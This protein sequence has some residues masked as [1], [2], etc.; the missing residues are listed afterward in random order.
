MAK[1]LGFE[2]T[3]AKKKDLE[4]FAPPEN[5]DGA[6]PIA[7][8]GAF[9]QYVDM[10]GSIKSEIELINR[11]RDMAL[12]PECDSAIDD[13][14]NEAVIMPEDEQGV[15]KLELSELGA[16]DSVKKKIHESFSSI[17]EKL[18]FNEKAYEIFRKE[19]PCLLYTSPSPRD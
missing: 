8:G 17:V 5:D 10:S 18:K 15:V 16:P 19:G 9:G 7:S 4:T 1:F 12:H 14:V 11:Y 2:I 6:L 13:I 3:R